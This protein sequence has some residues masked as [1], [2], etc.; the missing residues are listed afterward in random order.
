MTYESSF[1]NCC[2]YF[3]ALC[4]K[5]NL[6]LNVYNWYKHTS[7][8]IFVVMVANMRIHIFSPVRI[9]ISSQLRMDSYLLT[10]EDSCLLTTEYSYLLRTEDLC[11]LTT[12]DSYLPTTDD[13]YLPTILRIRISSQL[14][15]VSPL[16]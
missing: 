12:E 14:R 10:T 15:F 4:F 5:N 1:Y 16:S 9:R 11:L 2:C 3:W 7:L 6:I 8:V 13:S